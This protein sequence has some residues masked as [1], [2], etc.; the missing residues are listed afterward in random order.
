M[1]QKITEET[2]LHIISHN[3][4][5]ELDIIISLILIMRENP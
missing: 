5:C 4:N 3:V 1:F 2:G